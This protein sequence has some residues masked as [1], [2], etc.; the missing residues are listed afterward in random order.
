MV[1][2]IYKK[3]KIDFLNDAPM[4]VFLLSALP[5]MVVAVLSIF[6]QSLINDIYA[7]DIGDIIFAVSMLI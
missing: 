7:V 3:V 2:N 1:A 5:L 6:T 4:K